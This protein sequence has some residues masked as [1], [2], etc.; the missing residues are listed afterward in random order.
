MTTTVQFAKK[1]GGSLMVRI[2]SEIAAFEQIHEG[3]AV[4]I[5]I[6]KIKKDWFGMFPRLKPFTKE[7]RFK[8]HYD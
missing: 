1:V 8:S 2:P 7:D 3:E 6:H 5:A 4:E